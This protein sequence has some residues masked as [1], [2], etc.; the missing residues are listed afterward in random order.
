MFRVK[1]EEAIS[2]GKQVFKIKIKLFLYC[3][4]SN[5]CANY[6]RIN[7]FKKKKLILLLFLL[8]NLNTL[9]SKG[10]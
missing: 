9:H 2:S 6:N 3:S 1:V 10:F 5:S 4:V 7:L 8:S